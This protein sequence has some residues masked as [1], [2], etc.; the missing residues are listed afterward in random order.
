MIICVP[1]G[2][3]CL[4]LSKTKRGNIDFDT[5]VSIRSYVNDTYRGL[6]S[7]FVNIELMDKIIE[8]L[9]ESASR[10]KDIISKKEL[11]IEKRTKIRN[12]NHI[13]ELRDME[14]FS[15]A[16]EKKRKELKEKQ[17]EAKRLQELE[18][19]AK[20]EQ[21]KKLAEV[22]P[23][24]KLPSENKLSEQLPPETKPSDQTPLDCKSSENTLPEIQSSDNI[25]P[26]ENE[27]KEIPSIESR[28]VDDST[29]SNDN[30]IEESEE[31]TVEPT[32]QVKS[33]EV[34]SKTNEVN[35]AN[36]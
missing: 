11:F 30:N 12:E 34:E 1:F 18:I 3:L 28:S 10:S 25:L 19:K 5:L 31:V 29:K 15:E 8:R 33:S 35:Q 6:E 4:N 14:V 7:C 27:T 22:K 23:S 26:S 16:L 2:I 9:N 32:S 36:L 24:E 20:E 13:E 21:K 17:E